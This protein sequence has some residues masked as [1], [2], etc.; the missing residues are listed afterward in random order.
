MMGV[1]IASD[2]YLAMTV[3]D[4]S[5]LKAALLN[6]FTPVFNEEI[7]C[8]NLAIGHL[9]GLDIF[10]SQGNRSSTSSRCRGP[11]L[12]PADVLQSGVNAMALML[13]IPL[14]YL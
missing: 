10:Q 11:T 5:S 3:R 2:A 13:E 14:Y 4:G 12:T 9:S 7:V 1:N 8:V 6:N